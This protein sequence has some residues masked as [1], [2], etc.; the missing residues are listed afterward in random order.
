MSIQ[1]DGGKTNF[2]FEADMNDKSQVN[3]KHLCLRTQL[4]QKSQVVH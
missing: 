2:D 1:Y 3:L 4:N